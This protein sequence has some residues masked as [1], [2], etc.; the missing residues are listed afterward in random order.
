[1][2]TKGSSRALLGE[3]DRGKEFSDEG[4]SAPDADGA[5]TVIVE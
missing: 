3:G 2:E 4:W 1:M 5:G